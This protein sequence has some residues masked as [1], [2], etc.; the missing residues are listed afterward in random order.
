M[1]KNKLLSGLLEVRGALWGLIDPAIAF[2]ETGKKS[3]AIWAGLRGVLMDKVLGPL[4]LVSG[5]VIGLLGTIKL[6]TN[7][8]DLLAKGMTKLRQLEMLKTQFQPLVGGAIS[9]KK[10]LQELYVFA[11]RT[12]FQLHEIAEAS[13]TLEVL[14][15]GAIST[16]KGLR[17]VGDAAAVSGNG[18]QSVAFW[19][20]RLYDGLKSGR[21]IGEATNRLQEMGLMTG[22]VRTRVETL[23][24]SGAEFSMVWKEV[25]KGMERMDGGMDQLSKTMIGLESTLADIREQ[26]EAS[27]AEPF[28]AGEAASIKGMTELLVALEAPVSRIGHWLGVGSNMMAKFIGTIGNLAK[29]ATGGG[30]GLEYLVDSFVALGGAIVITQLITSTKAIIDMTKATR[31]LAQANWLLTA[32]ENAKGLGNL[33][34]RNRAQRQADIAAHRRRY[35]TDPK[36][37]FGGGMGDF[38]RDLF[39]GL[40]ALEVLDRDA[41]GNVKKDSAGN[42]VRRKATRGEKG[43]ALGGFLLRA[44]ANPLALIKDIIVGL[45][46]AIAAAFGPIGAV[47]AAV[48]AIGISFYRMYSGAAK[49]RTEV[50]EMN[51]EFQEFKKVVD[52][53]TKSMKTFSDKSALITKIKEKI[54]AA[55]DELLK[56][57][58]EEENEG[59]FT[60]VGERAMGTDTAKIDAQKKLIM[61]LQGELEKVYAIESSTL[62]IG[63]AREAQLARQLDLAERMS[64]LEFDFRMGSDSPAAQ[65][66]AM[67]TRREYL[68]NQIEQAQATEQGDVMKDEFTRSDQ[69][70]RYLLS[71]ER[72]KNEEEEMYARMG[73]WG[74]MAERKQVQADIKKLEKEDEDN[75]QNNNAKKIKNL[76]EQ[77]KKL[78][79]EIESGLD[80]APGWMHARVNDA[81]RARERINR[82]Y[83]DGSISQ[84]AG[85]ISKEDIARVS[86]H[87]Y[88][89]ELGIRVQEGRMGA[90]TSQSKKLAAEYTLQNDT[91]LNAEQKRALQSIIDIEKVRLDKLNEFILAQQKLKEEIRQQNR[92]MRLSLALIDAERG[93]RQALVGVFNQTEGSQRKRLEATRDEAAAR[94]EAEKKYGGGTQA[95]KDLKQEITFLS[96]KGHG[97]GGKEG[98]RLNMNGQTNAEY[99]MAQSGA[100]TRE[101]Q[102]AWLRRE[103]AQK[104]KA[105]ADAEAANA[106][107]INATN[108][109]ADAEKNLAQFFKDTEERLRKAVYQLD[110]EFTDLKVAEA[111]SSITAKQAAGMD[112]GLLLDF[113]ARNLRQQEQADEAEFRRKTRSRLKSE[114]IEGDELDNLV[115]RAVSQRKQE[116]ENAGLQQDSQAADEKALAELRFKQRAGLVGVKDVR[117]KEFDI[118]A[119]EELKKQI[120]ISAREGGTDEEIRARAVNRTQE[121]LQAKVL[122]SLPEQKLLAD[123]LRRIGAGGRAVANDPLKI[124]AERQLQANEAIRTN[125]GIIVDKLDNLKPKDQVIG[126]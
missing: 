47:V 35:G 63:K 43:K 124:L 114:G 30:R 50:K 103:I 21:P 95:I 13:K 48:A 42:D 46:R 64:A 126:Q 89:D 104:K 120:R 33:M 72:Y 24:K 4:S 32:S 56:L 66:S 123:S 118:F 57:Q 106:G 121:K 29:S 5:G 107:V 40:G 2:A 119:R 16:G 37:K 97:V 80:K 61:A 79:V 31:G 39:F 87:G 26:F 9:A 92:E 58:K 3:S 10:R 75:L 88:S 76:K 27:F 38:F 83:G 112:T 23:S 59:Y 54:S 84:Y 52:D 73:V 8:M 101:E 60:D 67:D 6:V 93:R 85:T 51:K 36:K 78:G 69:R 34:S 14:T 91:T 105:L 86:K 111:F 98:S 108:A 68:R 71:A 20:G 116:F 99:A 1:A 110:K 28:Q 81:R 113:A 15:R 22:E 19:V 65:I 90:E 17:M 41:Q 77:E 7:Q 94:L 11:A 49:T 109:L 74:K 25:E 102:E 117:Q 115:N 44:L 122:D 12:P 18:M 55:K 96:G 70:A 62:T 45:G 100:Q 53:S 82:L 125:T